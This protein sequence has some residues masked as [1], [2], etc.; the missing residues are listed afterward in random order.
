MPRA[1]TMGRMALR[2]AWQGGTPHLTDPSRRDRARR[3][4]TAPGVDP[5]DPH[6]VIGPAHLHAVPGP[7]DDEGVTESWA[8]LVTLRSW[9]NG[10]PVGLADP[11]HPAL[12]PF[13]TPAALTP[14]IG[15]PRVRMP[16]E[17]A[18]GLSLRKAEGGALGPS[19][20]LGR[21]LFR[22]LGPAIRTGPGAAG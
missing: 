20:M 22:W 7:L 8:R 1:A 17:R 3:S 21:Y 14:R 16:M 11:G 19:A 15:H 18:P 13:S 9:R 6:F 2:R 10:V 5:L 12:G 4:T